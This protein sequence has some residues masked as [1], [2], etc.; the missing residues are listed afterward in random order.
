MDALR[1][2]R[3]KDVI[4]PE[5]PW[6]LPPFPELAVS[7]ALEAAMLRGLCVRQDRKC[8]GCLHAESCLVPGWFDPGRQG[9]EK[10]PPFVLRLETEAPEVSQGSPLVIDLVLL[11]R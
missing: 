11:G 2:T 4:E 10:L 1:V 8:L 7:H 9:S 3:V 5:R 6:T